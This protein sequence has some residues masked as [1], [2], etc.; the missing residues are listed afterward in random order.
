MSDM[1]ESTHLGSR[2]VQ[3]EYLWTAS[4]AP[5]RREVPFDPFN[6]SKVNMSGRE[7]YS[8]Y[9]TMEEALD[10]LQRSPWLAKVNVGGTDLLFDLRQGCR[11]PVHTL[12]DVSDIEEL[13]IICRDGA[14]IMP[15][16]STFKT[17]PSIKIS[18]LR[19]WQSRV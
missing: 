6:L 4:S 13:K 15:V 12:A 11:P 2:V 8:Q 16:V 10:T 14:A 19:I 7:A 1:L 3:R 5:A 9:Q 18:W 17:R